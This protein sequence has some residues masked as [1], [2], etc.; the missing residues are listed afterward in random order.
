MN[1]SAFPKYIF[2]S[3]KP[4]A[5]LP[6]SLVTEQ[7]L[8]YGDLEDMFRLSDLVS[9]QVIE[10]VN[11]KISDTGRWQKRTNFINKVILRK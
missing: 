11:K 3:Y 1:I 4:E 10:T 7:V 5:D 2:W 6:E 8:L 9:N